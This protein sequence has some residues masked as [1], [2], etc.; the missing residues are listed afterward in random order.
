MYFSIRVVVLQHVFFLDE[1]QT[2]AEGR[3]R[4]RKLRSTE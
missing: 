3:E 4:E 2:T 1:P